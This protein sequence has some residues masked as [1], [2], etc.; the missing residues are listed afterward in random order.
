ML[1]YLEF[2]DRVHRLEGFLSGDL[3]QVAETVERLLARVH[4]EELVGV[5]RFVFDIQQVLEIVY[6][7]PGRA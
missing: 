7:L 2:V 6:D 1:Q 4:R 3:L 5:N